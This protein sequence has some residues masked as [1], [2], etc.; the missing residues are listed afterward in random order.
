[1]SSENTDVAPASLQMPFI[2]N[3]DD[4]MLKRGESADVVLQHFQDTYSK[5]KNLEARI[6]QQRA[7]M[8]AKLPEIERTLETVKFLQSKQDSEEAVNTTFE[9]T[10]GI[11]LP[12]QIKKT[13]SVCL[14]LGANVMVEYPFEEAIGLL[15]NNRVNATS[16]MER[17]DKEINFLKD[18]ITTLEVNIARVYNWDVKRR[19]K[20]NT[21]SS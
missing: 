4:F 5:F 12:A 9:L 17:L 19:K 11:H 20:Q 15:E 3:V 18:Q 2:E 16:T 8:K 6:N 10:Y 21:G 7:N 13:N 14:W 1:M